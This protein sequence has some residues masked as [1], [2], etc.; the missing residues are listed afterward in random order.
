MGVGCEDDWNWRGTWI[1]DTLPFWRFGAGTANHPAGGAKTDIESDKKVRDLSLRRSIPARFHAC[2]A[3]IGR[4]FS[5][6][7]CA[8]AIHRTCKFFL[9]PLAL[10][11]VTLG[12]GPAIEAANPGCRLFFS[13]I[14]QH[15]DTRRRVQKLRRHSGSIT[16]SPNRVERYYTDRTGRN[17]ATL[18][19]I[20]EKLTFYQS[21]SNASEDRGPFTE[22]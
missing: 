11:Q 5:R 18:V 6:N 14:V 22:K 19:D 21:W 17:A 8:A 16:Q 9:G 20:N 7:A 15:G 10:Q 1:A 2:R 12:P 3:K 13:S 4:H